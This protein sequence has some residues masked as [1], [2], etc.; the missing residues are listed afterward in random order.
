MIKIGFLDHVKKINFF[1]IKKFT[2]AYVIY[3]LQHRKTVD[4]LKN[5]YNAE[6]VFLNGRFGMYEY[7]NSD[8]VIEESLKL[9]KEL[10]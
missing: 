9:S 4:F 2:H 10:V 5:Y 3:N 8:K 1:E 7:M 6:G